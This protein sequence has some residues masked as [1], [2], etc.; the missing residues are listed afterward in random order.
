M[1]GLLG[2]LLLLATTSAA[3]LVCDGKFADGSKPGDEELLKIIEEH[4]KW[5]LSQRKEGRRAN[6]CRADL[7]A[8]KLHGVWL[9]GADFRGANFEGAMHRFG[10]R[11]PGADLTG[12][13]LGKS[14]LRKA[15]L[16][17]AT[18]HRTGFGFADL[19]EAELWNADL[20]GAQLYSA[21]LR[22]AVFRA[23]NLRDADLSDADLRGAD[24]AFAELH[25]AVFEP[26]PGALPDIQSLAYASSLA[27]MTFRQTPTALV[28]L[29]EQFKKN[30]LKRQEREITFAISSAERRLA[31]QRGGWARVASLLN[32]VLFELTCQYGMSP[33]RPLAV[34][35]LLVPLFSIP[36]AAAIRWR[37]QR[38]AIWILWLP[39]RIDKDQGEQNPVRLTEEFALP[40]SWL[41]RRANAR[42][43]RWL[44]IL[45]FS[46]YF[47]I[48]SIFHVGWREVNVGHWIA[49]LQSREYTL[50]ATGW[51]RVAAGLQSLLGV[52]LLALA[53]L[54]YFGRPFE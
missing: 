9:I 24:L 39:D 21:D 53:V 11:E 28:E 45:R 20:T 34:L 10:I 42:I 15:D 22:G 31:W 5:E 25:G 18:L 26:K 54:S 41:A 2:S 52:Y 40:G 23:A 38:G 33:G 27:Y 17:V 4:K 19:R 43:V 3:D 37:W 48:L 36:Y 49:R 1:T 6:L 50:R 35:A 14:D 32:F 30:G 46:V 16:S 13:N 47:S 29:R 44:R 7:R 51:V 12:A 8:A